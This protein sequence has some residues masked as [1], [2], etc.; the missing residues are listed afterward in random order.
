MRAVIQRVKFAK[1]EVDGKVVG[2][3]GPGVFTLLGVGHDD[4]REQVESLISK[5]I[6]LRVFEDE[7]GKMNLSVLEKK[8][9]HLIVSQFTLYADTKKGNRPSFIDAAKPEIATPLYNYALEVSRTFGV[10]TA[11][12]VFGADMKITLLNDGPVTLVLES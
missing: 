8:Y 7:A 5:I 10:P 2:E 9:A 12:G 3:I 6:K 4:T 11:G 1:V